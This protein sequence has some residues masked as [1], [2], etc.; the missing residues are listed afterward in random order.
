MIADGKRSLSAWLLL[1][2]F[3]ALLGA[4]GGSDS[5]TALSEDTVLVTGVV[6]D[7][8]GSPLAEVELLD[9]NEQHLGTSDA[10]GI[11]TL[12]MA[13]DAVPARV[14]LRKSGYTS[15]QARVDVAGAEARF[16][17]VMG[18]RNPPVR[19]ANA[20]NGFEYVGEAGARVSIGANS[21]VTYDAQGNE[22]PVTGDVLLS[23]TPIDVSRND[24]LG[25]F[26]GPFLGRD[27]AG[28]APAPI[29][30]YGTVEYVF[31]TPD[32]RP[33]NLASGKTAQIEIPVFVTQ[34]PDG[35]QVLTNT[36][37]QDLWSFDEASGNWVQESNS[38]V[39]VASD[40]S[41]TGM[42]LQDYVSHFS[43]WNY[44]IKASAGGDTAERGR[45]DRQGAVLCRN[46]LL[47]SLHPRR[48]RD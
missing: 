9:E 40:A 11:F 39:V 14:R 12:R 45:S 48:W 44:D 23:V 47:F 38:A 10:A 6:S 26:P 22:V 27:L 30:S 37:G 20:E 42:V 8:S 13:R 28:N 2:M 33:V 1:L 15:Q 36:Y 24:Q 41:P 3:S 31:A 35:T 32:G 25:A 17:A 5:T 34:H 21:L 46:P 43:W 18:V 7:T 4:C 19:I 29:L 16:E